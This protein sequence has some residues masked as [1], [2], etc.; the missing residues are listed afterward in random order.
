MTPF[1]YDV[2]PFNG[3]DVDGSLL[4]NPSSANPDPP[5]PIS[6]QDER[7]I[8]WGVEYPD[9]VITETKA[10]HN[11]RVRD[12]ANDT[13]GQLRPN[14]EELD[15]LR[16]PQGSLFIELFCPRKQFDP[17]DANRHR[18]P[19]ELYSP[20][21]LNLPGGSQPRFGLSLDKM[22]QP[23]ADGQSRPVWR[24]AI[25]MHTRGDAQ[26]TNTPI[27]RSI[28]NPDTT[29]FQPE[30]MSLTQPITTPGQPPELP[31]DRFVWFSSV[32]PTAGYEAGRTYVN[33]SGWDA[34]VQPQQYAVVG[35]R[36][37]T[38]VGSTITANP[39][40]FAAD[41]PQGIQLQQINH[42]IPNST[43][44]TVTD[45]SGATNPMI[46]PGA[47]VKGVVGLV[48][49][50][51]PPAL[52]TNQALRVGLS[53]TEPLPTIDGFYYDEP[54]YANEGYDD[55]AA[56]TNL[57]LDRP[58]D[59]R[60]VAM[61][62]LNDFPLFTFNMLASDTYPDVRAVFLQRLANPN[63]A[64]DAIYNPYITVDWSSIDCTVFAGDEDTNRQ[65]N[66]MPIDPVDPGPT[67]A[68][69]LRF[70]TRQKGEPWGDPLT[71]NL[72]S[73]RTA[74]TPTPQ[75][76][77]PQPQTTAAAGLTTTYWD[78]NLVHTLGYINANLGTPMPE[79]PGTQYSEAGDPFIIGIGSTPF[80]WLTHLD[81]PLSSPMELLLVS[82]YSQGQL[83]HMFQPLPPPSP[84]PQRT[85][86]PYNQ[87]DPNFAA[88]FSHLL[89]FFQ[90]GN[91]GPGAPAKISPQ[92]A[93]L[94]EYLEVP[95][96]F[97]GTEKWFNPG[98]TNQHFGD[99][100]ASG[101][102]AYMYRPPFNRL[103]RFA[104]P[105]RININTVYD[106]KVLEGVFSQLPTHDPNANTGGAI[107]PY[108]AIAQQFVNRL[109]LSR[110]G[111]GDRNPANFA[112]SALAMDQRYPT[113]FANPF[114]PADFADLMPA[115]ADMRR[116]APAEGTLMRSD[117]FMDTGSNPPPGPVPPP[118]PTPTPLFDAPNATNTPPAQIYNYNDPNR[119]AYFE[120]QAYQ[121]IGNVF[122]TQSNVY[123]VWITVG[124][125]EVEEN[126]P[127]AGGPIQI[128]IG[129]PDGYRLGQEVG[130][131]SGNTVRHRSFAII[132]RSVPAA[133]EPGKRHNTDK[134][135]L[136]RRFIE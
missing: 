68:G 13:S 99:P 22:A 6:G 90:T 29:S 119:N 73:H 43:G 19:L 10:M 87:L 82:C 81:R 88:P 62:D 125:F 121:K 5:N 8:V 67:A 11:R 104:D 85:F 59:E 48:A 124:Y 28:N 74:G 116:L 63:A 45:L 118:T 112:Q 75:S 52:W 34:H 30:N 136:L 71:A 9:L 21:T 108:Q 46:I 115:I 15:Q 50:M 41:S 129:H 66:A 130:A 26:A 101:T 120:Y 40:V 25:S 103:S 72:W 61:G 128:D 80:P 78:Y 114:R 33:L 64:W 12:T 96:P 113:R 38:Y 18:L 94:L 49:D 23:S 97:S 32:A 47:T 132:D 98:N 55:L 35:P 17:N 24:I 20:I 39:I 86:N 123:A 79:N 133:Y 36:P 3:W 92:L 51:M 102:V 109:I 60:N 69:N 111:Y 42:Y 89:N 122:S 84:G 53:I 134:M 100:A 4:T 54:L 126:R 37:T 2:N 93:R 70:G 117:Y 16:R 106:Q 110:Q 131:D 44:V 127:A 83:L 77:W 1:E 135:I 65:V 56:P 7:R 57:L 76:R 14:D 95:C 31:L 27:A 91:P 58:F 107:N 105:G